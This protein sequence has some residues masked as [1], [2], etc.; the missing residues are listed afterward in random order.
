M[1]ERVRSII[2]IMDDDS[3][4]SKLDDLLESELSDLLAA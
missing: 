2:A 3:A 4:A 1:I